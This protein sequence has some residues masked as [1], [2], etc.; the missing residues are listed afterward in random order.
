MTPF[1]LSDWALEHRSLVWYFMIAFLVAG[2][3]AYFN[4]GREEDP[5]FA[6]KTMVVQASWPGASAEEMTAQV[7]DRIEKKLEELPALEYT[8]SLTTPGQTIVFVYLR[9]STPGAQVAASW[10]QVRNMLGDIRAEFPA[11]MAG[12]FFNDSF[13]DVYGNV[14]AFTGDGLTPRQLRD[15]VEA[16]RASVLS[17][18]DV[19]RVDVIGAQPEAIYL[20]FSTRKLAGLAQSAARHRQ[21]AVAECDH[22]LGYRPSWPG[23]HHHPGGRPVHQRGEPALNQS[24]RERQVL[25]AD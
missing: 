5:A 22:V 8:R 14:Y 21:P 19:G 23:A 20:E 2:T 17:V 4:L 13:G 1:N 10:Q 18:P 3:V 11:G 7:A 24:E 6:I 25:P 12:P 16:A 9:D 15:Y